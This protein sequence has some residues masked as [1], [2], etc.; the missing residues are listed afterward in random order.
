MFGACD[1]CESFLP[2]PR[3]PIQQEFLQ[4]QPKKDERK[5]EGQDHLSHFSH[6]PFLQVYDAY[7]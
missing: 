2:T 5:I 7:D 1:T 4:T 6:L 3:L